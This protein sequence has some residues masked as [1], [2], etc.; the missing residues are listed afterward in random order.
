MVVHTTESD[1]TTSNDPDTTKDKPTS[2]KTF[3]DLPPELR[4]DIYALALPPQTLAFPTPTPANKHGRAKAPSLLLASK[5]IHAEALAMFYSK[6][7][8]HFPDSNIMLRFLR[9]IGAKKR[10][11]VKEVIVD[12]KETSPTPLAGPS[13]GQQAHDALTALERRLKDNGI[14]LPIKVYKVRMMHE[15]VRANG[16]VRWVESLVFG[17]AETQEMMFG[18]LVSV[19]REVVELDRD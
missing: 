7:T 3:L 6:T 18:Q 16:E 4:N 5:Q 14:R 2:G 1:N 15:Y 17:R 12:T 13:L 10:K 9:K 8:F 19:R 11:L